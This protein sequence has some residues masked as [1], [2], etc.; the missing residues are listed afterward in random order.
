[1]IKMT[2]RFSVVP[3]ADV[4]L[5]TMFPD[6]APLENVMLAMGLAE[7]SLEEQGLTQIK[8]VSIEFEKQESQG[9]K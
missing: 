6:N 2:V 1:M 4:K 9:T 8:I 7:Q 3:E 5:E